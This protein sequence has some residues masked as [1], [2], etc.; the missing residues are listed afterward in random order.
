VEEMTEGKQKVSKKIE[1][2]DI[3]NQNEGTVN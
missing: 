1:N 3:E 2:I